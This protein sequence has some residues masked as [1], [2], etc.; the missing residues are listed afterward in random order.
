MTGLSRRVARLEDLAAPDSTD[1]F[2]LAPF[3][4]DELVVAH[5]D[6][7]RLIVAD[8]AI[9]DEERARASAV[10]AEIE[11]AIRAKARSAHR[12]READTEGMKWRRQ[13]RGPEGETYVEPLTAAGEGDLDASQ[14]MAR[15]DALRVRPDIEGLLVEAERAV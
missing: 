2:G 15:R 5:L 10:V 12:H 11:S 9:D 6:V 7:C 1:P 4:H 13:W 14:V 3:L 8:P